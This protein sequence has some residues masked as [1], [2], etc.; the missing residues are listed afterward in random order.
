M[1]PGV[2]L[3]V[4]NAKDW[5]LP[6]AEPGLLLDVP[7]K[8]RWLQRP[9]LHWEAA[10]DFRLR[11]VSGG[12]PLLWVRIQ[13]YWDRCSF[14][15]GPVHAPWGLP[16]LSAPEVRAVTKEPGTAAWWEA[17]AWHLGRALVEAPAPVLY[18]GR[19]CLR[20]VG[21]MTAQQASRHPVSSM[22]MT[23]G[24][25]PSSPHSLET[26]LRYQPAWE[27]NWWEVRAEEKPGVLLPLRAPSD[28]EDG[29]IKSWRKR[30]R[31]G[32]LPPA[33]LLYVDILEKWLVLDGHDR[34]HAALLEGVAPPLMG[35]FPWV[36]HARPGAQVREQGAMI[37]A[38][39]QL[40]AGATPEVIDR[41]NRQLVRSFHWN[42]RRAVTRAWPL[43]GGARAWSAEVSA[44]RRMK[45]L[46]GDAGDWE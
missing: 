2:T 36:E 9:A 15:R 34:V 12:Q 23:F 37:A 22:E 30:A 35:L 17:W 3:T 18:A 13:S 25:L 42:E 27:E 24:V 44:W 7:A 5:D 20:P 14:V 38:E 46:P 40:R 29:R 19:W 39:L 21:V 6:G 43:K 33:L 26:V 16:A 4:P 10:A 28:A 32:T 45:A 11:L 41:V 8:G 1:H 31:D